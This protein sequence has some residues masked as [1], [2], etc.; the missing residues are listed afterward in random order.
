[1]KMFASLPDKFTRKGNT[2]VRSEIKT[3]AEAKAKGLR[4][5]T[6]GVLSGNLKGKTD[7]YGQPYTPTVWIFVEESDYNA[8]KKV[9][10][11]LENSK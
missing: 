6:V 8:M 10:S 11:I 5:R 3:E 7:L 4:Y 9:D 2:Y 1:M